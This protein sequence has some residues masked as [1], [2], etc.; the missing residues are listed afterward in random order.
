MNK[1]FVTILSI[2]MALP[3]AMSAQ[4]TTVHHGYPIDQVPFTSVKVIQNTFWGQRLKAAHDVT[5][6]LAFS[7]CKSTGRYDNFV[8]AAHPSDS[9]DVNKLEPLPFDDTDVYKTIEGASYELHT[10]PDKKLV[11]YIDSVL[12]IVAAAQEKDGYLYTARTMNPKHPHNWSGPTRWSKTED[13]SHELYNLGHM[14]DAACAHYQATKSTKFLNIAK[15]YAD[16]VI[17]EIGPGANQKHVVPGHQIAEMA[18]ARL[19]VLTGEKKYLDQAKYFLDMRGKTTIRQTYSQSQASVVNQK[20]AVGHAVRAG[21]MYAGMADV[22]ALTGDSSYIKAIDDIWNNIVGKK[23]YLTG[24]VGALHW[25]E[26]F[27]ANYELPN[28]TAYNETCAA[29]A[30]VYLNQRMFL[31]HG[32]AKYIDCLER[33]LYNG[34]ISGMSIDGGRFFYPNPLAADG[35]YKFNADNTLERQPWFGCACCP[36]NLS[37]FIPSVPGYFY[38]VKGNKVYVNLFASSKADLT[39][40]GKTVDF[41]VDTKYPWNGDIALTIGKNK[42][43]QFNLAIRIPGWMRGQVVPSDLYKF[44]DNTKTPWSITVNGKKV[45]GTLEKGYFSISRKW[46]KGDVVRI[47]FDMQP[48]IVKAND[49]VEA[50]RGRIAVERGPLVYCAETADN[51]YDIFRFVMPKQPQFTVNDAPQLLNGIKTISVEGTYLKTDDQGSVLS[52]SAQLK[53]IPYYAWNH[54]GVGKMLVW[55]PQGLSLMDE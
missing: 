27:G 34:V 10:Y 51:Q 13:L 35:K 42:A 8:R 23:Y 48:R 26:A 29:I 38:A 25:G 12:D 5:I 6:P 1:T 22:A 28:K 53:L 49:K 21:Y 15:R 18:L 3:A 14:V 55:I 44:E 4:K 46:K 33:T 41:T 7:K 2:G 47:H 32:D 52:K 36:S 50:D 19:Y 24:G 17:R 40:N 39:V 45:D 11:A 9:Y 20:E 37:R 43:G 54:R 30:Q 31:L 16:C